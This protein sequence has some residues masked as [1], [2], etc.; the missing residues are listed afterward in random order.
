MGIPTSGECDE[1]QIR[2]EG[3]RFDG[4]GAEREAVAGSGGVGAKRAGFWVARKSEAG[5]NCGHSGFVSELPQVLSLY[6]RH[7]P[8]DADRGENDL[9]RPYWEDSNCA[10]IGRSQPC[11]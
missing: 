10:L 4:R 2:S 1:G 9:K 8:I 5:S 3:E 11:V 6:P 7:R